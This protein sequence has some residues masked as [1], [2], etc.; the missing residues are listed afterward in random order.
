MNAALKHKKAPDA[1]Q[2]CRDEGDALACHLRDVEAHDGTETDHKLISD[3]M[4]SSET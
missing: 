4:K 1:A 3:A 2:K